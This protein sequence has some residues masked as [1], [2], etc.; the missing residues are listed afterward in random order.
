MMCSALCLPRNLRAA[1]CSAPGM[2]SV[3]GPDVPAPP[4]T[5][6]AGRAGPLVGRPRRRRSAC[7]E[8]GRGGARHQAHQA[9]ARAG[10]CLGCCSPLLAAAI[11]C[12]RPGQHVQRL[13]TCLTPPHALPTQANVPTVPAGGAAACAVPAGGAAACAAPGK[14]AAKKKRSLEDLMGGGVR[15]V[16]VGWHGKV[17]CQHTTAASA[18]HRSQAACRCTCPSCRRRRRRDHH[19]LWQRAGGGPR[20]S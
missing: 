13:P 11:R 17:A 19:W 9:A 14:P 5:S 12:G 18:S 1:P 4:A 8:P 6:P 20:P 16:V 15:L 7:A 3:P 10:R 2:P